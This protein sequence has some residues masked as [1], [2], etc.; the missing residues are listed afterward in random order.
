M[1]DPLEELFFL[2][3]DI[4]LGELAC[5]TS[6]ESGSVS[7]VKQVHVSWAKQLVSKINKGCIESLDS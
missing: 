2:S 5:Q 7:R 1:L 3:G 6:V 4:P